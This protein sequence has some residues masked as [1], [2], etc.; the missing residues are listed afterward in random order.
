MS[1]CAH[2]WANKK[3]MLKDF[4]EIFIFEKIQI[5]PI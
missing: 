5:G 4:V 3:I 1:T 2:E